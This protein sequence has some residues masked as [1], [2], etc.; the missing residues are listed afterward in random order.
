MNLSC[1]ITAFGLTAIEHSNCENALL[2]QKTKY[3]PLKNIPMM[4]ARR[5][6]I[7]SKLATEVFMHFSKNH[8]LEYTIFL[9]ALLISL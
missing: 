5:M 7:A 2:E 6:S 9:S 1:D 3:P 8:D 4:Q